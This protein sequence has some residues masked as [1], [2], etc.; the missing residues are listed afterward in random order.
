MDYTPSEL[1]IGYFKKSL[2]QEGMDEFYKW[3]NEN[4]DNKKLFFEA[5]T[6]FDSV[7]GSTILDI[8]DSWQRLLDKKTSEGRNKRTSLWRH[9]SK[10]AA[11]AS[12]AI[13]LTSAF[14]FFFNN[15]E[16]TPPSAE[17]ITGDGIQS[18]MVILSDGTKVNI[19]PKTSFHFA[20]DYGKKDRI[21]YLEGEAYFDVAKHKDK[22]F[23][24]KVNGQDIEALG[25]KFNVMAYASDSIYTTTLLEGSVSLST[26]HITK[27][28]VLKP[29]Q[30]FTYNKNNRSVTI[31]EVEASLYTAWINGY[32]YFSDQNLKL[33]LSKLSDIYGVTFEVLSETLINKKFTG[34][35]YRGQSVKNIM[36]IINLSI[37][38][39]YN[40]KEQHIIIEES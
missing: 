1:I 20:P 23:I 39:K 18:D 25:T 24:V 36:E 19:G 6:I 27:K 28:T 11:V 2:D 16:F 12:I 10:Y 31:T 26:N 40:M 22:P 8:N 32:Y 35:F 38:I 3:V 21:V 14:F 4:P 30:Q 17:Y 7:Y 5:K 37:P 29:D 33:I 13:I 15:N 9:M 34:T